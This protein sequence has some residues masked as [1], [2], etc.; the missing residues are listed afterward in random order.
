MGERRTASDKD[1]VT[2]AVMVRHSPPGLCNLNFVVPIIGIFTFC[3]S[4]SLY[5][6]MFSSITAPICSAIFNRI[7][8]QVA[9]VSGVT[10]D[11]IRLKI[12]EH[13]N[14]VIEPNI[15]KYELTDAQNVNIP[16]WPLQPQLCGAY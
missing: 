12:A 8:S 14:A 16:T 5:F 7:T 13:I 2:I 10:C 15:H 3:A 4:V 11:V 1:S 9:P 6:C